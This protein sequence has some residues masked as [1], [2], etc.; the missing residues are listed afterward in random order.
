MKTIRAVQ[1]TMCVPLS[2]SVLEAIDDAD[3]DGTDQDPQELVPIE[4]RDADPGWLDAVVP[5]HPQDSD[6]RD[7]QQQ[8]CPADWSCRRMFVWSDGHRFLQ[9][10]RPIVPQAA[11]PR[12]KASVPV[13]RA[14]SSESVPAVRPRRS[15]PPRER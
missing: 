8:P 3:D 5:R 2:G 14:E 12:D 10:A 15:S 6:E 9:S 13:S 1:L 11:D 7:D 4:E